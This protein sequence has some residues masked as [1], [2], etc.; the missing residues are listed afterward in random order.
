MPRLNMSGLTKEQHGELAKLLAICGCTV[1]ITKVK[2][3]PNNSS[4]PYI[5]VI[6]FEGGDVL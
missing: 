6:E 1:R 2:K 3:N 4:S 5:P